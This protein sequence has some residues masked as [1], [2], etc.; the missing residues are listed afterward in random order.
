MHM[1]EIAFLMKLTCWSLRR[2]QF[3]TDLLVKT[4]WTIFSHEV[5]KR[6]YQSCLVALVFCAKLYRISAVSQTMFFEN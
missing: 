4:V 2:I 6:G 3:Q 5:G 1:A